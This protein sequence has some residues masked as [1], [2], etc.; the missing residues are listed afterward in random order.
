MIVPFIHSLNVFGG[1]GGDEVDQFSTKTA[2]SGVIII[3][4]SSSLF[5]PFASTIYSEE[6][7]YVS[8]IFGLGSKLILIERSNC[9]L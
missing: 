2:D 5:R 9:K 6:Y 3:L 7:R 4:S 8:K 1:S